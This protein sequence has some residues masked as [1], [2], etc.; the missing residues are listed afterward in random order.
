MT[1]I[2]DIEMQEYLL[3][4][5]KQKY[6]NPPQ[7]E[8]ICNCRICWKEKL[9]DIDKWAFWWLI[10]ICYACKEEKNEKIHLAIDL[11]DLI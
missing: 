10:R 2:E 3:K 5:Y 8:I 7:D 6:C 11:S 9:C 1:K 4:W